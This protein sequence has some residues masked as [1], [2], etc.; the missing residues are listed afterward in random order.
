[1][2]LC[3]YLICKGQ[4]ICSLFLWAGGSGGFQP[5]D[6][7][8]QGKKCQRETMERQPVTQM[9]TFVK[10]LIT[11]C[12]TALC[13]AKWTCV[14]TRC[15]MS[16]KQEHTVMN[17]VLLWT[18]SCLTGN[19]SCVEHNR[20]QNVSQIL[21]MTHKIPL[22]KP[23]YLSIYVHL[24]PLLWADA[25]QTS[26]PSGSQWKGPS[27]LWPGQ[28]SKSQHLWPR[29]DVIRDL[30]ICGATINAERYRQLLGQHMPPIKNDI[31]IF[32]FLSV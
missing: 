3:W 22:A 18:M 14:L 19:T 25:E 12:V 28:S 15:F 21:S 11:C 27:S 20:D 16:H 1:M 13:L 7:Q 2:L 31:F 29:G 32:L 6:T 9:N 17:W 5:S 10:N 24:E 8:P 26:G 30:H 4:D 23:I